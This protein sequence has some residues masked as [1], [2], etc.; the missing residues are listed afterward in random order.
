MTVLSS[1]CLKKAAVYPHVSKAHLSSVINGKVP[2]VVPVRSFRSGRRVLLKREWIDE[3]LYACQM[4]PGARWQ[5]NAASTFH[6]HVCGINSQF[7]LRSWKEST[8]GILEQIV[9]SYLVPGFGTEW[10]QAHGS[11]SHSHARCV[12][13]ANQASLSPKGKWTPEIR[14]LKFRRISMRRAQ[15]SRLSVGDWLAVQRIASQR[16][17]HPRCRTTQLPSDSTNDGRGIEQWTR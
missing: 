4:N 17:D 1:A 9:L 16:D 12:R 11:E 5:S 2:G 3:W 14:T 15:R 13:L 7:F 10:Q 8:A 6:P